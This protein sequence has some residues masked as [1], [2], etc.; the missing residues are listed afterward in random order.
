MVKEKSIRWVVVGD[1]QCPFHDP[2]AVELAS[3]IIE[4][5]NPHHLVYNGDMIDF[6]SISKHQ[7]SRSEI[8]EA[9]SLQEE[10][11]IT[12]TIVDKLS[13]GAGRAKRHQIDGNHENRL[14]RFL[15]YGAQA[16]LGSLRSLKMDSV[17]E[18]EKR[19]FTTYRPYG[20]G[21]WP[22]SNLF[23]YHG[24]YV[25]SL[26]GDSV[27]KEIAARGSSVIMNHVHRRAALRFRQGSHEYIGIE[28]GC[29][30]QLAAGYKPMTN[31]AHCLTVI[32]VYDDRH[33]S[34]EVV[35]IIIDNS[36]A[37][38]YARFRGNKYSVP[39]DYHDGIARDW[40]THKNI[41]YDY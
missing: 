4:D 20:E 17:F 25:S 11:D 3:Q 28:N 27:K 5:F 34:C 22:T 31:W 8:L 7:P 13:K 10:I 36:D 19:G 33:F 1:T 6:W 37:E 41:D 12:T 23:I 14:E 18:Y 40:R 35:D 24:E 2:R 38:V 9:I 32:D 26:P 21:I 39:I 15:G 30:C 29:L 16:V